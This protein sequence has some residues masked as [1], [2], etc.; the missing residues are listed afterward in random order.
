MQNIIEEEIDGLHS[1]RRHDD[2]PRQNMVRIPCVNKEF[3]DSGNGAGDGDIFWVR[4]VHV[5]GE[6]VDG[7]YGGRG[8]RRN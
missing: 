2:I 3:L 8:G 4:D 6:K 1:H 5:L 7:A